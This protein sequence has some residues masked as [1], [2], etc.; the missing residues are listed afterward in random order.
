MKRFP[1]Y[2]VSK[3][4]VVSLGSV[5]LW[6]RGQFPSECYCLVRELDPQGG[7]SGLSFQ[8]LLKLMHSCDVLIKS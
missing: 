2:D 6:R 3:H 1:R 8:L 7:N 5:L 4:I